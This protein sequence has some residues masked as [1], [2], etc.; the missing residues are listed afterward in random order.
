MDAEGRV[1]AATFATCVRIV[2]RSVHIAFTTSIYKD[3]YK[4][5]QATNQFTVNLPSF[6]R[7]ILEKA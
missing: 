3:T 1:D 6:D 5:T 4:N 2:H 7:E